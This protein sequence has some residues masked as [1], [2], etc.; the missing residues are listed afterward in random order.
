MYPIPIPYGEKGPAL[1]DWPDLRM[2]ES[3]VRMYFNGTWSN[4][5]VILGIRGLAD[6]DMDCIEAVIAADEFFPPTECVF[7]RESSPRSHR[8]YWLDEN[9]RSRRFQDP[10]TKSVLLEV[11]SLK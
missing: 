4:L 1:R 6:V 7:G 8:I 9:T 10:L 3:D 5:G 2:T 11:R